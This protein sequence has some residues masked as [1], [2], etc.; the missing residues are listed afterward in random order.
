MKNVWW[1]SN[2]SFKSEETKTLFALSRSLSV[3]AYESSL[4]EK[5]KK[6]ERENIEEIE[7][8]IFKCDARD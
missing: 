2:R 3:S 1:P 5:T 4:R 6:R 8:G 7:E